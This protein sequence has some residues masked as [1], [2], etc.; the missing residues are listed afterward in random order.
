VCKM[1]TRSCPDHAR[2]GASTIAR[3]FSRRLLRDRVLRAT[4][5]RI[6]DENLPSPRHSGSYTFTPLQEPGGRGQAEGACSRNIRIGTKHRLPRGRLAHQ[7]SVS[8]GAAAA[9][10][11][12]L[13][14]AGL[15]LQLLMLGGAGCS[16]RC[17]CCCRRSGLPG[18]DVGGVGPVGVA[19]AAL[20]LLPRGWR[21]GRQGRRNAEAGGGSRGGTAESPVAGEGGGGTRRS[22]QHYKVPRP[23]RRG[24]AGETAQ[25]VFRG[26]E[27]CGKVGF[28]EGG[29][30]EGRDRGRHA[31]WG[32]GDSAGDLLQ[33]GDRRRLGD[34]AGEGELRGRHAQGRLGSLGQGDRE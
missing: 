5:S 23:E 27:A 17:C 24:S 6:F 10:A 26:A 14:G 28:P 20:F 1:C 33:G 31:D 25:C 3:K 15:L 11:G 12:G 19:G 13:R 21:R 18:C 9:G 22:T 4:F 32:E 29:G 34:Q 8:G 7:V 30:E 16:C 2:A